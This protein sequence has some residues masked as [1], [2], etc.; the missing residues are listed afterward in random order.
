MNKNTKVI[1]NGNIVLEDGIIWDGTI[2]I[3][4]GKIKEVGKN[5]EIPT[6]AQIIDACGAYVGPGFFDIHVHGGNGLSTCCE[7]K[8]A[9]DYFL[10]HGT[11]SFLATP[12]YHM[13]RDTMIEVI[14]N[15]K[16]AKDDCPTL[17]GIYM[18]GPYTN[19]DYGSHSDTNPWRNGVRE[20][21]YIPIVDS[22][23]EDVKVWTV[24]PER[25]DLK[26]F[27]KYAKKVN[28]EVVFAI[29]HSDATPTE[30]KALGIYQPRI[31]THA[32]DATP[33]KNS[34]KG[35]RGYGIDEYALKNSE[36][37]CELISDSL[38]I[39]VH[40][41]M[42]QLLLHNKGT[43]KIILITDSTTHSNPVPEKFAHVKD[44]NFDPNG[45][46]AGSKMTMDQACKNIMSSTNCG[47][48]Q[49]FY[50]AS[51]AP[52]KALY[53]DDEIGSI[54]I[55]KKADIVFVDDRFNV[56]KVILSGE[57]VR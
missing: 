46:I 42:Q 10:D 8:K 54:A 26:P 44:L 37:Y 33:H 57:I 55:G 22:A 16:K 39:H 13:D 51:T 43:E 1:E 32:M 29:G 35:L 48:A 34:R 15:I 25:P 20:E 21:D 50:M 12:D 14:N 19:P 49:A 53:M 4:N 18:E 31:E 47:I 52:S 17:K 24:A 41:E 38:G 7:T 23:G 6:D 11:T 28:P 30:V 3:E 45:G 9:A 27:L 56:K 2:L 40:P 36:V 5:I